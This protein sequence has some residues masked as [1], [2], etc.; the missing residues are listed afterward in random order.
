LKREDAWLAHL[1]T[2]A[3][4]RFP[5]E[6]AFPVQGVD[7]FTRV[8]VHSPNDYVELLD[9][10]ASSR[11]TYTGVYSLPQKRE[12]VFHVA[13]MDVDAPTFA[14]AHVQSEALVQES[15][16]RYG[17]FPR[18]YVSGAKGFALY[19]A[20]PECAAD[21]R[22]IRDWCLKLAADAGV[23]LQDT[24]VLGEVERVSRVPYTYNFNAVEKIGRPAVCVPVDPRWSA[25]EML[26]ESREPS[27]FLA[28][29]GDVFPEVASELM[30]L[31]R[32]LPP[33]TPAAEL[34]ARFDLSRADATV[35][36]FVENAAKVR[37]GRHRIL[38][39]VLI[40]WCA[41][42]GRTEAET[43]AFC[44]AWIKT[45]HEP[46]HDYREHVRANYDWARRRTWRPW[47]LESFFK[48]NPELLTQF[49]SSS[50]EVTP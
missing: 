27:R 33:E 12:R 20:F 26:Q 19:W 14:E 3:S 31:T 46:P 30:D 25:D 43:I 23:T 50:P 42:S 17:K 29:T 1:G 5:R 7:R 36:F 24:T 39:M 32:A 48:K 9:R 37:D 16:R 18:E 6:V 35:Q 10:L 40:P 13:Y 38:G 8:L 34:L 49:L 28:P 11:N 2:T 4:A 47:S 22:A 45:T 41:A 21:P 15:Y 44:G